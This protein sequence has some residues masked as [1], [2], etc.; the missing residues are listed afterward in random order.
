MKKKSE[1]QHTECEK[2]FATRIIDKG[3]FNNK[4]PLQLNNKKTIQF[5]KQ[6]KDLNRHYSK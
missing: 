6:I 5:K 2:I 1:T 3:F 4:G